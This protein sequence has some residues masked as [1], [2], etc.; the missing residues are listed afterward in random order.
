[1]KTI[2]FTQSVF[3]PSY[4]EQARAQGQTFGDNAEFVGK[5]M[6]GLQAAKIHGAITDSECLSKWLQPLEEEHD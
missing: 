6:F 3:A 2:M 4:E 5:M 1:M